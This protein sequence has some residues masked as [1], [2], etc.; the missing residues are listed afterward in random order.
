MVSQIFGA[1]NSGD[2]DL[3]TF[4]VSLA[5]SHNALSIASKYCQPHQASIQELLSSRNMTLLL[6]VIGDVVEIRII[7]P[8]KMA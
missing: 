6:I 2:V 5:S 8:R 1:E 3:Y 7:I 4:H